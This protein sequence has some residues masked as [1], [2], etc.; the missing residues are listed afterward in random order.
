MGPSDFSSSLPESNGRMAIRIT[1]FEDNQ[2]FRDSL[3]IMIEGTPGYMLAGAYADANNAVSDIEVSQPDVVLMDIEMPGV[4]GITALNSI[5]QRFPALNVLMQTVFED[6]DKVF[7]AICNGA[8]GYVLK[9]TLPARMLEAIVETY[10]GGAPMS[11]VIARKVLTLMQS[12]N[13]QAGTDK[14]KIFLTPREKEVLGLMVDGFSYKMIAA[15]RRISFETV[16]S[17]IKNIYAKLHVATMTE[18]VAKA[19]K[20]RI[21]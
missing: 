1:I 21:V 7:A 14:E 18:A 9:N 19:I 10:Q 3:S 20:S 17:H 6:E 8:S 4:D 2:K 15:D 11:P 5:K 12:Q 16:R 13:P